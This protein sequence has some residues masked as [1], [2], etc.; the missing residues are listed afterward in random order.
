MT[1]QVFEYP[2]NTKVR[3]Y[4]R[5]EHIHEQLNLSAVHHGGQALFQPLFG[6]YDMCERVDYRNDVLKDL[7]KYLLLIARWEEIPDVDEQQ[8]AGLKL[9]LDQAKS[10]LLKPQHI[11]TDFKADK[12]LNSIRQRLSL[13]GASC[14]FDL[15][16]LHYWLA[17]APEVRLQ[18]I[19]RWQNYFQ[20]LTDSVSIIL[21]LIRESEPYQSYT[22]KDGFYQQINEKPL[23]MIRV[24]V[25][26][27]NLCYPTISGHKNRFA[28]HMVEFDNQK[29]FVND[30][31]FSL[32]CCSE[33]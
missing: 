4:L 19:Q 31:P 23:A 26:H 24:K 13:T 16:Q 7:E 30:T 22:A 9:Q 1:E 14:N 27:Q 28:I 25:M 18:Q 3:S 32:A 33:P 11:L 17:Q 20:P 5:L 21:K 2:L 6:L 15:P 8:L 29:H 10:A 12:F